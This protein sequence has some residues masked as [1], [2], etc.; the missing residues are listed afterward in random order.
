MTINIPTSRCHTGAAIL[1]SVAIQVMIW[2][3][4][5]DDFDSNMKNTQR[6]NNIGHQVRFHNY[7]KP[8]RRRDVLPPVVLLVRTS[9]TSPLQLSL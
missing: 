8:A 2:Q 9:A 7:T 6:M 3:A 5:Y 4:H 1:D